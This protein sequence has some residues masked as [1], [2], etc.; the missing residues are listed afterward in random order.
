MRHWKWLWLSIR[1][2]LMLFAAI[3]GGY[4]HENLNG[5]FTKPNWLTFFI[6]I[7]LGCVGALFIC[8]VQLIN[9][10]AP[11]KWKR[12]NWR[13]NPFPVTQPLGMLHTSAWFIIFVGFGAMVL[14]LQMVPRLWAWE[15]PL[16]V[17]IG[18][19][20]GMKV[21]LGAYSER[22]ENDQVMRTVP[23][24]TRTAARTPRRR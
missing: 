2:V 14:E 1:G 23:L 17:G 24:S 5:D 22:F 7:G 9:P 21:S 10:F 15:I 20:I 3:Q 18:L 8:F 13:S 11:A 4:F 12:P 19:L 16:D 6:L